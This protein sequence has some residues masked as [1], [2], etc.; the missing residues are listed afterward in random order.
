[1]KFYIKSSINSKNRKLFDAQNTLKRYKIQ[2]THTHYTNIIL[3]Q[4]SLH[5]LSFCQTKA[6]ICKIEEYDAPQLACKPHT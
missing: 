4:K 3:S 2:K 5:Q 6:Y 1:M